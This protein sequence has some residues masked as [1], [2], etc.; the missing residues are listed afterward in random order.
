MPSVRDNA[1]AVKG[2]WGGIRT[3]VTL[4]SKAVFKTAALVHSATHPEGDSPILL[5][6]PCRLGRI[7]KIGTVPARSAQTYRRRLGSVKPLNHGGLRRSI[8]YH[9]PGDFSRCLESAN[10]V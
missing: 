6:R 4:A 5:R 8:G 2:G 9:V 10:H 3:P 1:P 7:G